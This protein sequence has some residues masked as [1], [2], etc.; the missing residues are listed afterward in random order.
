M[1]CPVCGEEIIIV[2]DLDIKLADNIDVS[3]ISDTMELPNLDGANYRR[4]ITKTLDTIITE[5]KKPS[6]NKKII[7]LF[8]ALAAIVLAA[9][10]VVVVAVSR[11]FSYDYQYE[12]A[13]QEYEASQYETAIK[14]AKHLVTLEEYEEGRLLLANCYIAVNNYDAAIA[15]LYDA[16]NDF[17][18]DVTLYDRIVECYE[19][20]NDSSGIDELIKNSN[21]S[22]LA[23]RYSDYVS[24]SP[25]F[26]L[27]SG[28]YVTPDPIKLSAP[29]EGTIYYTT[30]GSEPS[31]KSFQY[32]GPIP[33][34][35][36]DNVV[37]AMYINEKGIKS[38]V[39][40][41][42]YTV[43]L[44]IPDEPELKVAPG[45][46]DSPQLIEVDFSDDVT[47]YYTDD[48]STPTTE[49]IEYTGALLMPIGKSSF[50]FI[51]VN[52][53]NI[54]SKVV[55][56]NYNLSL[57]GQTSEDIAEYA[58]SYQLTS[59]GEIVVGNE[60]KTQYGYKDNNG[61]YF[62]ILEYEGNKKSGRYFAVDCNTGALFKFKMSKSGDYGVTPL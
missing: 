32:K 14:T 18:S 27:E 43:E 62:V 25:T 15:V 41:K 9:V 55:V 7:Y 53:D 2:S 33:L 49:S 39:V 6:I 22:T 56:G 3:V 16:L 5:E 34:E 26:S 50:S 19:A 60:Y 31:E 23:L 11:Y 24:I 30:D 57:K 46:Y 8:I 37:S 40:T 13:Q 51:S 58:I 59:M 45:S 28:V 35:M 61:T 4:N 17:P 1:Y 20:E 38:E 42:E 52:A 10:I 12:K 47:V 48:G 44:D 36:G 21:D 29:G 54:S